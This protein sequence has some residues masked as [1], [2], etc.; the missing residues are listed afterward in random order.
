MA[1]LGTL[2]EGV[3]EKCMA[4]DMTSNGS[5]DTNDA[6]ERKKLVENLALNDPSYGSLIGPDTKMEIK[7]LH[8]KVDK[9][10]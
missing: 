9:D 4:L 10:R 5:F 2:Y 7:I 6:E 3:E 8:E 1:I